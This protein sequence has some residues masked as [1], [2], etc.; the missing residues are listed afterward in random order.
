MSTALVTGATAG[1]GAEFARHLAGEGYDLVLVARQR[2]RLEESAAELREAHGVRVEVLTANLADPDQCARVE[3]RLSD[4][5]R[6]VDFLVND[7]GFALSTGFLRSSADDEE[8]MLQVM[9]RAV[10]RLT[11]AAAR[12]MVERGHG[13]VINVS[14][15]A[16]FLPGGT[17]GAAKAYV[18]AF[19][20]SVAA[21]LG[22]KGVRVTALC[23]GFTHTEF[24]E[25]AHI[26]KSRVP[27]WMW[28]SAERVVNDGLRD[29]R[30]GKVVSIPS[31]RYQVIVLA[32]HMLP[33]PLLRRLAR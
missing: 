28:L 2:K 17:Y 22:A 24:H 25:R 32:T 18:T 29:M 19:S 7:A 21:R 12:A 33:R 5:E 1:L 14:S 4:Q 30:R 31:H 9:V 10:V 13:D 26:D 3:D 8:R 16:G 15:V 6:P 11:H 20:E 23:P 27:G